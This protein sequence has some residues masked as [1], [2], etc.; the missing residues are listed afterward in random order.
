MMNDTP[1]D[2]YDPDFLAGRMLDVVGA[3]EEGFAVL[4]AAGVIQFM[5]PAT[6][7]MFALDVEGVLGQR[8][9]ELPWEIEGADGTHIPKASH[10]SLLALADGTAHGPE[11]IGVTVATLT[12]KLWLEVTARPLFAEDG[13]SLDGSV[14]LFR[15]IVAAREEAS[16]T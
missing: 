13:E 16:T 12:D 7:R 4:D 8:L 6:I 10:P 1:S 5:N 15:D 14:A 9:L 11:V 2:A 3:L